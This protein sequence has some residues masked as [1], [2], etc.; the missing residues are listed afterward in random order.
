MSNDKM[1]QLVR[2]IFLVFGINSFWV[3]FGSKN[4]KE[5]I[6][7]SIE[8][9]KLFLEKDQFVSKANEL[10]VKLT[11]DFQAKRIKISLR[12]LA[13]FTNIIL[14]TEMDEIERPSMPGVEQSLAF[15]ERFGQIFGIERR[16]VLIIFL[17]SFIF[18]WIKPRVDQQKPILEYM[19]DIHRMI[20][21][22][23]KEDR[24]QGLMI[25]EEAS[26]KIEESVFLGAKLFVTG[27]KM[28]ENLV[29]SPE[30]HEYV[31]FSLSGYFV[32]YP[33]M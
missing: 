2:H 25:M 23:I 12:L 5:S 9:F 26:F 1:S 32:A 30:S 8:C 31:I 29:W 20:V 15:M 27:L 4:P 21:T 10:I 17:G 14:K 28:V 22:K 19:L 7:D 3:D 18:G 13:F 16:K 11:Q 6:P 33:W 24:R